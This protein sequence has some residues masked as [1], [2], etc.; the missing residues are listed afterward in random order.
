MVVGEA[1]DVTDLA[2]YACF[3]VPGEG[4]AQYLA[5]VQSASTVGAAS[6]P[7]S[8]TG[9]GSPTPFALGAENSALP[10]ETGG[11]FESRPP[12]LTT[13]RDQGN[14]QLQ[15]D[16]LLRGIESDLTAQMRR[17]VAGRAPSGVPLGAEGPILVP[18]L[19]ERRTFQVF[20]S[21]DGFTEVNAV[22]EYVGARAAL[23]VDENSPG[24]G[25]SQADLK[26]FSDRFDDVMYP[27]IT[28][29]FGSVSD[30]DA[31]E[32]V[33]ILFTPAVNSLT[34]RGASGFVGGFFF[35]LDLLPDREGSNNAEI[36]YTL[37]PDPGGVFSDPRPKGALLNVV[38][39][40]LAHEFQHMVNFN[41]RVLTRG[42]PANEAIWLSE[43][44]AQY[45]EE[46]VA[47]EYESL[48]DA[49][50][51]E[52]FR[53]GARDR[54]RRYLTGTDS[55]SLIV[56]AGAGSLAERGA[57]LLYVM[58]LA[59]RFGADIVGRLT[60]TT[61]T[62]VSNIEAETG[63]NWADGLSDWWSAV[64]LD[65][66][67]A[68]GGDMEYPTVDL[69]AFLGNPFPLVPEDLGGDFMRAGVLPS[70]GAAYYI[71]RPAAGGSTTLRL[72]G[73]A[74]GISIPQSAMRMRIIRIQ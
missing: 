71:V 3:T 47:L 28:S 59:D 51:L 68:G 17:G 31:N 16:E 69:P 52:L 65:E 54:S 35:G 40:V 50:G 64:F 66:S 49:A 10:V 37:V 44:L 57:G 21:S 43:G 26:D 70:A 12:D 67:G 8:L 62:G 72:G 25:Y 18:V 42:A 33:V 53:D 38:P 73:E 41:E 55:V 22:A 27:T 2:G 20:N 9:L 29:A 45:A 36:F 6:H 7:F 15:W 32:R 13:T 56:S 4:T 63:T 34:P 30:L 46:L 61:R 5:V 58:Y 39:A 23:F 74:G 1:I 19:N 48:G 24:S 60:R 14:A 11:G